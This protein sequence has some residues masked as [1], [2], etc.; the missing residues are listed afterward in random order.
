MMTCT[1]QICVVIVAHGVGWK[2]TLYYQITSP[3]CVCTQYS[4]NTAAS[5]GQRSFCTLGRCLQGF[6]KAP[7]VLS[8]LFSLL[9]ERSRCPLPAELSLSVWQPVLFRPCGGCTSGTENRT[10]AQGNTLR[11][12]TSSGE[13]PYFRCEARRSVVDSAAK[14]PYSARAAPP[15]TSLLLVCWKYKL[16]VREQINTHLS[17][18][19]IKQTVWDRKRRVE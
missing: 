9:P 3:L 13:S 5:L 15:R 7:C 1:H 11:R 12:G 17:R 19:K 14:A 8:Q 6:K 18:P 4:Q 16:T 10:S 2:S